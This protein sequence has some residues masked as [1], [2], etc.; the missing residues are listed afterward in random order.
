LD[1]NPEALAG[2]LPDG[3]RDA[4]TTR[5]GINARLLDGFEIV[6]RSVSGGQASTAMEGVP[7]FDGAALEVRFFDNAG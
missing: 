5:M 1:A 7:F 3:V 2:D 6:A 4:L